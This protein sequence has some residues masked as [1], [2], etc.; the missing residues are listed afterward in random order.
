M[1]EVK[2][3]RR[4]KL[5]KKYSMK[6]LVSEVLLNLFYFPPDIIRVIKLIWMKWEGHMVCV[7]NEKGMHH[8]GW[9]S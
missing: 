1:V 9:K 8:F 7:K 5:K 2:R 3:T 6:N 4:N